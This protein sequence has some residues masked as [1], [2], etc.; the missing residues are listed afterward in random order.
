MRDGA[1]LSPLSNNDNYSLLLVV[2]QSHMGL[3]SF[4]KGQRSLNNLH[5]PLVFLLQR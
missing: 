3:G 4:F 2:P 1:G 5:V